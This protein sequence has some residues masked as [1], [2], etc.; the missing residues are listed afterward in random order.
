MPRLGL[1]P[2]NKPQTEAQMNRRE[3]MSKLKARDPMTTNRVLRAKIALALGVV[4]LTLG[5]VAAPAHAEPN[6]PPPKKGC[7]L[8]LPDK[9]E[10]H[11]DGDTVTVT[12]SN[13]TKTTY[14]CNDGKWEVV[15]RVVG[16]PMT[17][18]GATSGT[19]GG[20]RP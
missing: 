12:G 2:P 20:I 10:G 1:L 6:Q 16:Q 5:G 11:Y 17:R 13:G 8:Q 19:I 7:L 14:R 4:G 9:V 3:T 18:V 15:Q